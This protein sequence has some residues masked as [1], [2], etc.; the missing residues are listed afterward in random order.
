MLAVTPIVASEGTEEDPISSDV[1]AIR[2][3]HTKLIQ[4]YATLDVDALTAL[5]EPSR[6]LLIYHP[7]GDLRFDSLP[8]VR[9]GIERM[10]SRL[11]PST[12][13]DESQST[14]TVIGDV[15]WHTY[16]MAMEW[17]QLADPIRTRATE[18]WVRHA[19]GWRLAHAHWSERQILPDDADD[20]EDEEIGAP[21]EG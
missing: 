12:W 13:L 9:W 1:E 14:V 15:A 11:G 17:E 10:L 7:R 21:A 2:E 18:I 3:A 20:R 4:A 5:L 6:R 8:S 16:Q 19:A